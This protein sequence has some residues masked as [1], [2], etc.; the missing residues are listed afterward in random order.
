MEF[1][2]SAADMLA[3]VDATHKRF[4]TK[5]LRAEAREGKHFAK[6][7]IS[8]ARPMALFAH[9]FFEASPSV[10]ICHLLGNQNFDARVDDQRES[11]GNVEYLEATTTL[12][13]YEDSLRMEVLSKEGHVAA[14]GPVVAIGPKYNREKITATGTAREHTAIRADHLLLIQQSVERKA[15][16]TYRRGTVLVVAIDDSVPF[17]GADD[18][19]YLDAFAR[20]VLLPLL[21]G[22]NFCMLALEGSDHV[23]LC[24]PLS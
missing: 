2:R 4:N 21:Q 13:T 6:E 5:T 9:R 24:Y 23:H 11:K 17:R 18:V 10:I 22:S 19:A 15:G 12:M 20:S 1:P 16:K 3:W 7:L 14:Y 8:E